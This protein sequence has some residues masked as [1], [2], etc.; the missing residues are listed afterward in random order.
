MVPRPF[1][2]VRSRRDLSDTFTLELAPQSKPAGFAFRPGQFNMLYA[3]GI[4]EIAISISGDPG[5]PDRLI[6]TIRN[7]AA[8]RYRQ[9]MV[10]KL[11]FWHGQFGTS[12]CVGCGRCIAWC[13][14]G[15]DITEE[16]ARFAAAQG[17][18]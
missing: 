18:R 9:W 15:I 2:V 1:R 10:H 8:A 17:G 11:G 13:P 14:V 7:S 6:H 12:G 4:G 16:A 3:F 5:E